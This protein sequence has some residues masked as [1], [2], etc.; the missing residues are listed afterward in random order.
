[1]EEAL[2]HLIRWA[3]ANSGK[4]FGT[5]FGLF[6]GWAIV[7]LGLIKGLLLLFCVGLGFFIGARLDEG[8]ELGAILR[9]LWPRGR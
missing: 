5:T 6:A 3:L 2:S 9:R 4:L 7:R 8:E 1:M